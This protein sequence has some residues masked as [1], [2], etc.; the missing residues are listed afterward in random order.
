M[1]CFMPD[2]IPKRRPG[3]AK[4]HIGI[5]VRILGIGHLGDQHFVT[6]RSCQDCGLTSC[7]VW[8]KDDVPS[9]CM[10][11]DSSGLAIMK[12]QVHWGV[13]GAAAIALQRTIPAILEAPSANLLALASREEA[14]ARVL[15]RQLR[16]PRAYG[17]YEQLLADPD[18]DA[19]YIPLPNQLHFDWC[20]RA[21]EAGK[22]V[23]CEKPLCLTANQVAHLCAIRDRTGRHIEEAFGYRNHPQWTKVRELIA[24]NVIGAVRAAHAVIAKQFLDSAD[25]RNNAAAG[26]GALYDLGSYAIS[27]CNLIFGRSP[28]QVVATLDRDPR[29]GIDRLTSALLDYGDSHATL[30]VASQSGPSSW[31]THQQLTVLGSAGW[32]RFDFPFAHARP[33]PC[34]IELGDSSSVGAIPTSAFEFAP[35]NQYLLQIERFSRLLLGNPEPS[36]PIEDALNTT[37]TIEAIFVSVHSRSWQRLHLSDSLKEAV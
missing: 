10:R 37:Q 7:T 18:L 25:V 28:H 26:G 20:V 22:H 14:K 23:L 9:S 2:E 32:L 11:Y 15:A 17:R 5:Q 30:T 4:L 16:I 13:L 12:Q 3:N 35:V 29:F 36:W 31:A 27:A 34:R 6:R 8:Y 24:D 19:I 33:T 1:L 21:L